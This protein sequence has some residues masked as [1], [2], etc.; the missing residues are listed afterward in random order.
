[1]TDGGS[2]LFSLYREWFCSF[3]MSL[4]FRY[5]FLKPL[6]SF[7]LWD[8][9][10]YLFRLSPSL[11]VMEAALAFLP[12]S[13]RLS[14]KDKISLCIY[15]VQCRRN[16]ESLVPEPSYRASPS[17]GE[18]TWCPSLCTNG[19]CSESLLPDQ[20]FLSLSWVH[21]ELHTVCT[22]VWFRSVD[23]DP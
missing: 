6:L 9:E 22:C 7:C 12:R 5:E 2:W 16:E 20:L 15:S 13:H 3:P 10:H 19:H 17:P 11:T 21:M 14:P 8:I 23:Q 4:H 18:F 1:M